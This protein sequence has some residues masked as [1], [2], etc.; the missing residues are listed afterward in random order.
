MPSFTATVF[1]LKVDRE[2]ES[3]LTLAVPLSD[4][5]QVLPLAGPEKLFKVTVEEVQE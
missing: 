3:K 1:H 4:L 2:G 5:A